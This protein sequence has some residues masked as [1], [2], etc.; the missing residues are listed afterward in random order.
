M[1]LKVFLGKFK[2]R[3]LLL[4]LLGMMIFV[5]LLCFGMMYWLSSYTHHG[6]GIEL[7]DLYGMDYDDAEEMLAEKGLLIV[8][9]DT[10]Y[11]KKLEPNAIL[12]QDPGANTR[13]KAGR[14]IYVAIN[15][16]SSPKIKLPDIIDNSSYREAQAKLQA[17]GFTLLEPKV[18]DG[19][20]DWVYG[21][22]ANGR[23]LHAG[24][25]ISN[26]IPLVLVIGNGTSEDEDEDDMMLEV[27]ENAADGEQDEFVEI[28]ED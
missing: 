28:V 9:N 3:F 18:I 26:E 14:T 22:L 25:M 5:V 4:H 23:N 11:N 17:Y 2:S 10:G 21:V 13:V 6:E 8:V 20:R 12:L 19:E 27:P 1:D 16:T 15:S 24:D 7:P